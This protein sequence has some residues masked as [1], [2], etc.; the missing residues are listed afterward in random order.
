MKADTTC[1]YFIS[2][3]T[4]NKRGSAEPL[5]AYLDMARQTVFER[6]ISTLKYIPTPLF[7]EPLKFIAH[8]H[9]YFREILVSVSH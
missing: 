4:C 8:G 9:T 6:N 3:C 7:E 5:H 1:C 2:K